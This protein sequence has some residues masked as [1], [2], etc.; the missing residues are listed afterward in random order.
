[1]LIPDILSACTYVNYTCF[2]NIRLLLLV[3]VSDTQNY[4]STDYEKK[5]FLVTSFRCSVIRYYFLPT[6]H[7]FLRSGLSY[8]RKVDVL[9]FNSLLVS[10]KSSN[11]PSGLPNSR[12]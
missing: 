2:T 8:G 7:F 9:V 3:N 4:S 6:P 1:M 10:Q 12:D 5:P 11:K